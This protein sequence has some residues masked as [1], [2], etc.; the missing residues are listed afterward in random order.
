VRR[1]KRGRCQQLVVALVSADQ[2]AGPNLV[3]LSGSCWPVDDAWK[4]QLGRKD[5]KWTERRS[6]SRWL[7]V[8][9]MERDEALGPNDSSTRDIN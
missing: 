6:Q 7:V 4:G 8:V 2:S 5:S 1:A 9:A 3:V